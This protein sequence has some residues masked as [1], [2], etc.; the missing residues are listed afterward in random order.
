MALTTCVAY[1][2]SIVWLHSSLQV[3]DHIDNLYLVSDGGVKDGKG[4]YGWVIVLDSEILVKACG[5]VSGYWIPDDKLLRGSSELTW[6]ERLICKADTLATQ[7]LAE[8]QP[9]D[10][11]VLPGTRFFL[12]D[13]KHC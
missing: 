5:R 7:A 4:S 1:P 13:T 8:R 10:N 11:S 12:A 6:P 2:E 3:R 9:S